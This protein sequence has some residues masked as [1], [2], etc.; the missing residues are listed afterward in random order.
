MGTTIQPKKEIPITQKVDVLVV[1][2]G[3]GG[4]P[5]SVAAPRRG[6]KTLLVGLV[7]DRMKTM[8][9]SQ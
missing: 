8:S 3:P 7:K 5:A 9:E 2:G 4:F 1:G 6:A